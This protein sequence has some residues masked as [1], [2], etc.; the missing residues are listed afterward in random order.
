M[1]RSKRRRVPRRQDTFNCHLCTM[2]FWTLGARR[3]H[4]AH[5]HP[6]E[7]FHVLTE[8]QQRAIKKRNRLIAVPN[9][10]KVYRK[11]PRDRLP[12]RIQRRGGGRP[13]RGLWYHYHEQNAQ[14]ES[15]R[16]KIKVRRCRAC[17]N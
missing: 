16:Q 5:A 2:A 1:K 11:P 6:T 10:P 14:P 3:W 4:F 7:C 15:T 12:G 9:E 8:R 17:R 13:S